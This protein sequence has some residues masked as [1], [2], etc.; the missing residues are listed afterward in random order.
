MLYP[1]QNISQVIG[2]VM[3]PAFAKIQN[4]LDKVR[5]SYKRLVKVTSLIA[6]PLMAILFAVAPEFVRVI[7]GAKWEPLII[8]IRIFCMCGLIQSVGTTIG[9]ILLSQ[10]RADL[11]FRLGVINTFIVIISVLFGLRWGINGVAFCYTV[12]SFIWVHITFVITNK[13]IKLRNLSFYSKLTNS[14]VIAFI[15]LIMLLLLK[16]IVTSSNIISLSV[17]LFA[18]VIFYLLILFYLKQ[19]SFQ[20]N[21]I[22]F[23]L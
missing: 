8:L 23:N 21:K 15:I 7:Y 6:F 16:V 22:Q 14:Y 17:L 5:E 2:K 12:Y 18:S 11:Q 20:G 9:N 10:G 13:L 3:F 19:I 1:L 4:D